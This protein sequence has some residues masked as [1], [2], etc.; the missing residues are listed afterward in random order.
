M[1]AACEAMADKGLVYAFE[2]RGRHFYML[3]PT[4]PGL[5]EF[6]LMKHGRLNLPRTPQSVP[7]RRSPTRALCRWLGSIMFRATQRLIGFS[8]RFWRY[9]RGHPPGRVAGQTPVSGT[10][11][12]CSTKGLR[13]SREPSHQST[14]RGSTVPPER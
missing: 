11:S 7:Q 4:A 2:A 1:V 8:R 3:F 6:P 13:S 10:R 5:F 14:L 12:W 9:W